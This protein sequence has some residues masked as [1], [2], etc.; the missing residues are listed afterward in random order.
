MTKYEIMYIIRPTLEEDARKA[1]IEKIN[2]VFTSNDSEVTNVDEWGMRQLAYEIE[3]HSKGYYVVL[4]VKATQEAR[5]EFERI[6]NLQ[7][8]IIRYIMIKDVR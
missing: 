8:D 5:A 4:N 2:G 3:K 7:E 6:V 1:I